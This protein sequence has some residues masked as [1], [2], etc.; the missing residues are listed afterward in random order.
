MWPTILTEHCLP[1]LAPTMFMYE[2]LEDL[3][4]TR[5]KLGKVVRRLQWKPVAGNARSNVL[6]SAHWNHYAKLWRCFGT[7]ERNCLVPYPSEVLSVAWRQPGNYFAI[8]GNYP[9][10][11]HTFQL[12]GF[13]PQAYQNP[14]HIW[15]TQS[16]TRAVTDLLWMGQILVSG[17][18]DKSV[19]SWFCDETTNP[20]QY[21]L[22]DTHNVQASL[23]WQEYGLIHSMALKP[24]AQ[25]SN[26]YSKDR[27]VY[28]SYTNHLIQSPPP[29]KLV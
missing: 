28:A 27:I 5:S 11:I 24:S 19:R 16:H 14:D 8:A 15:N 1:P 4:P 6:L 22:I 18:W 12:N 10:H 3:Q 17:S 21:R 9:H 25:H 20:K 2:K 13:N 23:L 29:Y 26:E 7:N